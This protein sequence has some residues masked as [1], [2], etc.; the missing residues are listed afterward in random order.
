MRSVCDRGGSS[1]S[2]ETIGGGSCLVD[3]KPLCVRFNQP[4]IFGITFCGCLRA[5]SLV[6]LG[7]VVKKLASIALQ[8]V[9]TGGKPAAACIKMVRFLSFFW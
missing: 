5:R 4:I 3:R 2:S 6:K 1:G 7:Q 8:K 9:E